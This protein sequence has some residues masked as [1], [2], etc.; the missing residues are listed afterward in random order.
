MLPHDL[1]SRVSGL[2]VVSIPD[3][4]ACCSV[5][6]S[7]VSVKR[8]PFEIIDCFFPLELASEVEVQAPSC[9]ILKL[10]SVEEFETRLVTTI[11]AIGA[12]NG[13]NSIYFRY[14]VFHNSNY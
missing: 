1:I 11:P 13:K 4:R 9:L 10:I 12:P 6:D 14:G 2:S 7:R 3:S 8:F 5:P